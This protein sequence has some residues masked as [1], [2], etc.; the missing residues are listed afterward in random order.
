MHMDLNFSPL[1]KMKPSSWLTGVGQ[2]SK[3]PLHKAAP[4]FPFWPSTFRN[5][6]GHVVRD[7]QAFPMT[8]GCHSHPK[9]LTHEEARHQDLHPLPVP[10][11]TGL[12]L[13]LLYFA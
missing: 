4:E 13:S 3:D 12:S 5:V 2:P 10:F 6:A 8:C 9:H 1:R 11:V 7:E